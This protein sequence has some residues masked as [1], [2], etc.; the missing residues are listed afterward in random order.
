MEG[1]KIRAKDAGHSL[2]PRRWALKKECGLPPQHNEVKFELT[3]KGQFSYTSTPKKEFLSS[4]D[5]Y[6]N[7]L[8]LR[9]YIRESYFFQKINK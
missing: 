8:I 4:T 1:G 9:V 2:N 6:P 5:V 7:S 3:H